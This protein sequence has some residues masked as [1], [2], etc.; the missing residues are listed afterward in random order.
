MDWI[1]LDRH[2]DNSCALVNKVMKLSIPWNA[3]YFLPYWGNDTF[4]RKTLPHDIDWLTLCEEYKLYI[5]LFIRLQ[6]KTLVRQYMHSLFYI[7]LYEVT[8][9]WRR[10]R[11]GELN[12]LYSSPNIVRVIKSRRIR[13]AGHVARMGEERRCIGHSW[14]NR[15]E[16]A[17][18][19]T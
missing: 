10:L 1:H 12:D 11:N 5:S 19:E 15:R 7:I 13:W 3:W 4:S 17:T 9:E 8:G 18:G 6:Q 2:R 14:G 16:G